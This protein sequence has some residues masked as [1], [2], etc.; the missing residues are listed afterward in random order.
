MEKIQNP[1]FFYLTASNSEA[2]QHYINTI[3][4]GVDLR[5]ISSYL[6]DKEL[7]KL[8]TIYGQNKVKAWGATPGKGSITRWE[9][10]RVGDAILIYRKK[11]FEYYAFVTHKLHNPELAKKLWGVNAN[12]ETW[13]YMYFLD[14]LTDI[15][16]PV[17]IFNKLLGYEN[18]F[19]PFGFHIIQ[20]DRVEAL[21]NK[22]ESI[23]GFLNY[24][25]EG[26]WVSEDSNVPEETQKKIIQ[27]RQSRQ[28]GYTQI[29]EANLENILV[30]Q[31]GELESGLKLIKRQLDTKEVGRL[32]LLCEDSNGDLVVVELKRNI[33]GPSIMDQITRYMGWIKKNQAKENQKVRGIIVVASP[34]ADLE[35][36]VAAV[37]NIKVKLFQIGFSD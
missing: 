10:L 14:S 19:N 1:K 26:K 2:Y 21:V 4:N 23:Q 31:V 9:S 7:K 17:H 34:D 30:E 25:A 22:Y 33:A 28:V 32:D 20:N 15:S 13:E 35:Y 36:R 5:S 24:L 27:E 11:N 29:L 37:D 18:N 8:E 12:N 3:E 6:T 16:V